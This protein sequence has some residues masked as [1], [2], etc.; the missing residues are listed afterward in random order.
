MA[1][2]VKNLPANAGDVRDESLI[3]GSEDPLEKEMAIHSGILAWRIPWTEEPG[4]LQSIRLCRAGQDWSDLVR[5]H[6]SLT[7]QR[8]PLLV[9]HSRQDFWSFSLLVVIWALSSIVR[10]THILSRR[11]MKG[12]WH[13]W[14]PFLCWVGEQKCL[15]AGLFLQLWGS[16]SAHLPEFFFE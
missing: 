2:E 9:T 7:E 8:T 1:L 13:I 10:G 14:V 6:T 15:A 5:R 12:K 4:G 11:E 3:P 16:K